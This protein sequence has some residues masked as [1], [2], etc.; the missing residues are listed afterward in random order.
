MWALVLSI[1]LVT[2]AYLLTNFAYIRVLGLSGM[3]SSKA[4]AADLMLRSAGAAAAQLISVLIIISALTSANATTLMGARTN[5]ALGRDFRL[6][7][8][9]GRWNERTGTPTNAL[10]VQG[11]IALMLV[12]F[13]A[14]TRKGFET[15][16]EFTAPVFWF[17]FLMTG[18]SL[19]VLRR[20]DPR[21]ERPFSVPLYPVI[22]SL[23]CATSAYLLYSSLA[24]TGIGALVGVA[25]LLVGALVLL[26]AK[27]ADEASN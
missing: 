6:F 12:I 2:L 10:L 21:A 13:G 25:V 16:V 1:L 8:F 14:L 5:Y 26:F 22:P 9:L 20:R 27:R 19:F 18:I 7:R 24:Y 15:M 3:A 23:F 4:L 11:A 17:F